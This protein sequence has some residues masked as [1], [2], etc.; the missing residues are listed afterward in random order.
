MTNLLSHRI[1]KDNVLLLP[2]DFEGGDTIVQAKQYEDKPEWGLVVRYNSETNVDL[3]EGDVV[4]FMAYGGT[5]VRT[6]GE[7][8]V[9]VKEEDIISVYEG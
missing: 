9:Y 2:I 5:V 1:L 6:L 4:L 8:F 7:D 3:K